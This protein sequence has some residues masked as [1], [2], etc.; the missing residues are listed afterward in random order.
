MAVLVVEALTPAV[1]ALVLAHLVDTLIATGGSGGIAAAVFPGL[2]AFSGVL[3]LGAV[4][5]AMDGPL[6]A[7]I[8]ARID[9]EHRRDVAH[10]VSGSRYLAPLENPT[11]QRLVREVTLDPAR[12]YDTTPA[13]GAIAQLRWLASLLG[14]AASCAVLAWY[15]WWLVP[16][17]LLPA[18]LNWHICNRQAT[19][20]AALWRGAIK[21]ELHADVWRQAAVSAGEGKDIRIFGFAAWMI[22]RMQHHIVSANEAFWDYV[23]RIMRGQWRQF[24]LVAVGLVPAY[25]AVT[26]S[27]AQG[28]TPI[29]V[30][31]A[32]LTAGWSVFQVLG[33]SMEQYKMASAARVLEATDRLRHELAVTVPQGDPGPR[34]DLS[35]RP[36]PLVRF[37]GV[38][39]TYPGTSR[40]VL[41]ELD[42]EIRPGELLA[43]VGL[44][45]AGKSTLIKLLSGLYA[46][47]GGRVTADGRDIEEIDPRLWR[48]RLSVVFQDFV[49]YH[50]SVSDNIA[51]GHATSEPDQDD[52]NAAARDAGLTAVLERLSGGWETPLAR[53]REGGVDLSG[54]QWQQVVLARA[55]YAV[56][57]GARLLILDEPTA[58]LDVRTEFDVFDRLAK[59]RGE[60]SVV[61]ISHRLSTVRMADRIVML[62]GGRIT[63]S[64]T[65]DDLMAL[66]GSYAEMFAIQAERF[67]RGYDERIEEGEL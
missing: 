53:V 57:R 51:L 59:H 23:A 67:N 9:G 61:L 10:L 50:L 60:T 36:P 6:R 25:A 20:M 46:P 43:I 22:D 66:G 8:T 64:G 49:R 65:H 16:L 17:V 11:V 44:N 27:A 18:L 47:T 41:R 24:G 62:D 40:S 14:V 31:A 15:A 28:S 2:L 34:E 1:T 55:L 45:G 33:R 13:E 3:L 19:E 39:F 37:Q 35:E 21:G 56:R 5:E 29:G 32:V 7:G 48:S 38:S 26:V 54:G 52:L 42:L 12:G 58:H 63:E 4:G 30:L